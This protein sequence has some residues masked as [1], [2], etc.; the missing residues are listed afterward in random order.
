MCNRVEETAIENFQ[1]FLTKRRR[2][3]S[4]CL[5]VGR[6]QPDFDESGQNLV[7]AGERKEEREEERREIETERDK[8]RGRVRFRILLLDFFLI[9]SFFL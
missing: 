9:F 8:K 7:L 5:F 6:M 3:G 2:Q 4:D 1:S